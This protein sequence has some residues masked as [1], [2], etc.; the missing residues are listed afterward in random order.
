LTS[1]G[2][3]EGQTVRKCN[4]LQV[5]FGLVP[6]KSR[7]NSVQIIKQRRFV[8]K[9]LDFNDFLLSLLMKAPAAFSPQKTLE[10]FRTN[11]VFQF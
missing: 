8:D 3:Y 5:F 4:Y 2:R 7:R 10:S 6:A 1:W 11:L 9:K